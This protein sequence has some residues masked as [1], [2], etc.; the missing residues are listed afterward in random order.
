MSGNVIVNIFM[1]G[2]LV[3]AAIGMVVFIIR[4]IPLMIR[5]LDKEE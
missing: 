2:P 5:Y 1:L 4:C 3:L